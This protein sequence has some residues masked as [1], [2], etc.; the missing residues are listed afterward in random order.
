[1]GAGSSGDVNYPPHMLIV[2]Q[3]LLAGGALFNYNYASST[4]WQNPTG[5]STLGASA[6]T[7]PNI[8]AEMITAKAANPYT[9]VTAYDPDT[10]LAAISDQLDLYKAAVLALDPA[11]DLAAAEAAAL[12]F[13]TANLLS[14]SKIDAAVDAFETRGNAAFQ[15]QVTRVTGGMFDARA[16]M[17]S[18]FGQMLANME[19]ER[20][21]EVNDFDR[22]LRI[23]FE[24]QRTTSTLQLVEIFSKMQVQDTDQVYRATALTGDLMKNQIVA[25]QDQIN[26]DLDAEVKDTLWAPE[27]F[28]YANGVM[29]SI[30]GAGTYPPGPSKAE[31]Q[32]GM[33]L[34]AGA[35][36]LPLVL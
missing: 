19:H 28:K 5:L 7:G 33:V 26:W 13:V 16:V 9:A 27:L 8:I 17:T 21:I 18:Q 11:A 1:M 32:L 10:D 30:A 20:A 12:A 15:R 23:E 22:N 3:D 25:K 31:R 36:I 35:A 4:W 34:S 14:D 2:Q 6:Y 24:R 29:S